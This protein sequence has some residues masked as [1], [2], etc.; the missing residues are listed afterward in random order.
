MAKSSGFSG[1]GCLVYIHTETRRYLPGLQA[2]R[3]RMS[4]CKQASGPGRDG[5]RALRP[6][7]QRASGKTVQPASANH[8]ARG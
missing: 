5:S 3:P 4:C 2:A 8:A 1:L 7:N 6:E